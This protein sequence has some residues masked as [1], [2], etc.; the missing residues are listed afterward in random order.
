MS[1]NINNF[2]PVNQP[3]ESKKQAVKRINR[4]RKAEHKR[5]D[6]KA[7]EAIAKVTGESPADKA[8]KELRA[9]VDELRSTMQELAQ[10]LKPKSEEPD[11]AEPAKAVRKPNGRSKVA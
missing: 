7:D 4:W 6:Q 9:T 1:F 2:M 8:N 10:A 11:L 5:I 3:A